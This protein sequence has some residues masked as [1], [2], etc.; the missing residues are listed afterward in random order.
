MVTVTSATPS[1]L[2]PPYRHSLILLKHR[3]FLSSFS[4]SSLAPSLLI[5]KATETLNPCHAEY[6]IRSPRDSKKLRSHPS[7]TPYPPT[8]LQ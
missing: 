2:Q 7:K 6:W 1:P 4:T 8:G 3:G 5:N